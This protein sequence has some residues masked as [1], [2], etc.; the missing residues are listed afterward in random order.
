M[1]PLVRNLI[2]CFSLAAMVLGAV[3]GVAALPH[4]MYGAGLKAPV[5]WEQVVVDLLGLE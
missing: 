4:A 2:L 1:S 5:S 3:R